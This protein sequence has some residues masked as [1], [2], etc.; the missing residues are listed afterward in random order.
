MSFVRKK[1]RKGQI[2]H[3][4]CECRW[5]DGKPRQRVICYLGAYK[6]VKAAYAY[7]QRE[8]KKKGRKTY[9]SKMMKKLQAYL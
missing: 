8:S 5:I 1:V 4:L 3:Y 9:A 7:W 2:Y 6:T